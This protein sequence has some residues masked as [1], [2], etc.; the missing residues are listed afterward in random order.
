M[1]SALLLD[2][3]RS[4]AVIRSELPREAADLAASRTMPPGLAVI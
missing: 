1:A 3:K 2:G 4:A